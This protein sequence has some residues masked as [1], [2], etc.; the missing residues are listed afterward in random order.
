MLTDRVNRI[1]LS[2]TL[3]ISARAIQMKAQG[4][5][6]VD[7]GACTHHDDGWFSHRRD[8]DP[9]RLATIVVGRDG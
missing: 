8:S 5:D 2:P 3:R 4:I 6:V 7:F 9:R 1:Q